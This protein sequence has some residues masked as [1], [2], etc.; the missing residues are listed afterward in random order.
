[1][2]KRSRTIGVFGAGALAVI[3]LIAYLIWSGYEEAIRLAET[4][5]RNNAALIETRLDATFRRAEAHVLELAHDLPVAALSKAAVAQYAAA[6]DA[7]LDVRRVNFPELV[8]L[9]VFDADGDLIYSSESKTTPRA[10]A[11]DRDYFRQSRD[12]AQPGV[13]FSSVVISRITGRPAMFIAQAMR[14]EQGAFR[15]VVSASVELEFFQKLFQSL[16]VGA[17]GAIGVFRSDT[18]TPVIRWPALTGSH[19]TPLPPGSATRAAI[20]AGHKTATLRHQSPLDGVARIVSVRQLEH[21][22]FYVAAGIAV[23]D[24]LAGWR[25]RSLVVGLSS[26]LLLLLLLALAGYLWRAESRLK[27]LNDELETRVARRTSELEKARSAAED[28]N[29]AKSQFLA[30]MSHELRTPMNAVLGMLELLRH[31]ELSP[32][33]RNYVS[34]AAGAADLLLKLLN[35]V[36]DLS[37]IDAGKMSIDPQPFRLDHL[38][39]EL[40][41]IL[42]IS[43]GAKPVE[44]VFDI[45]PVMP[46]LLVGDSMCL[47]QVLVNL[48]GNAIKFTEKGEIVLQVKVLAC[49]DGNATLAFSVRDTGIG[50]AAENRARVFEDFAQAET[51]TNRRF[52]GTGL[53]LAISRRLVALMGGELSLE[54]ALGQGSTFRFV[55]TLAVA[56]EPGK[57][58][59]SRAVRPSETLRVLVVDDNPV[60]LS[61]LASM[62]RSWGW[63]VDVASS[64]AEAVAR[65]QARVDAA[66]PNYDA[67]LVD[68]EMPGMDGWQ[69]LLRVR[70]LLAPEA[71]PVVI[72]VTAHSREKLLQRSEQDRV[73]LDAYLVKPIT[74]SMLFDAMLEARAGRQPRP[75]RPPPAA[76]Q[77]RRLDGLRLLVVE[78]NELNQIIARELLASQGAQIDIAADGEQGVAAV[79][80]AQVP[81]DAVLMDIQMPV[82]DGFAATRAIRQELGRH[83][84]PVIAMTANAM[85]SDRTA[86]LAAG[87]DDH[88]GKPVNLANL[89]DVLLK[90]VRPV[91]RRVESDLTPPAARSAAQQP[92]LPTAPVA[93]LDVAA[94]LATLDGDRLLYGRLL[95]AFL[96][97]LERA[98]DE[99]DR[100]LEGG[101]LTAAAR[102]LHTFKGLA[103]TVGASHLSVVAAAGESGLRQAEDRSPDQLR[104]EFRVAAA[105]AG[106]S[107]RQVLRDEVPGS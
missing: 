36:L 18:F 45:D 92:A 59:D 90:H 23:D 78:D 77:P 58:A 65:V 66:Q 96:E 106:R 10:N 103:A 85:L 37:K 47:Q 34:N 20:A 91:D 86:C 64:G 102:L 54:S 95:N 26:L 46:R 33:Q 12:G 17:Q 56:A 50:I 67:L 82:M 24:A 94:A 88:V 68:W 69:T 42:S 70:Q 55:L 30:N 41:M 48:G 97:Q 60:A 28:A 52:G 51:S 15:G 104:A 89:V 39:R 81:Y 101:D 75:A 35:S 83:D 79:R 61:V 38:L 29:L 13:F 80:T 9:R 98:P 63:Q 62:A 11:A 53:G 49:R 22:P 16:D 40:S 73:G 31:T 74:A 84:L 99:L 57:M 5:S 107:L 32:T 7:G 19:A 27:A 25:L 105:E 4:T 93:V 3:A 100:L 1:M 8:G 2:D 71:A 6:I 14:D 43:V 44:V 76:A 21:Y 72:M 87:M